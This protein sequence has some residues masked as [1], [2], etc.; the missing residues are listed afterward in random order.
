MP[1]TEGNVSEERFLRKARNEKS[2]SSS[3]QNGLECCLLRVLFDVEDDGDKDAL[4]DAGIPAEGPTYEV[5]ELAADLGLSKF[6]IYPMF[7]EDRPLSFPRAMR[8]LDFIHFKN[9]DDMRL[10]DFI[11]RHAGCTAMPNRNGI[12]HAAAR[13]V[14]M[15]A[16]EIIKEK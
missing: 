6:S 11:N 15:A 2:L 3:A 5:K 10:I 14:V 4:R 12:D 13:R 9:P 7:S 1:R 16:Y 8:I